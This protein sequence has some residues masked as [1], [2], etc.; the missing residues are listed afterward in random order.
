MFITGGRRKGGKK[1]FRGGRAS[2][3]KGGGA[4][5][6]SKEIGVNNERRQLVEKER[7]N[8][9]PQLGNRNKI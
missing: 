8:A 2:R 4:E 6:F 1:K 5:K 3:V 7:R 9:S